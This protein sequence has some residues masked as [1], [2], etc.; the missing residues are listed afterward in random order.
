[1]RPG[2][3]SVRQLLAAILTAAA[4]AT[5][6][7]SSGAPGLLAPK[8]W[9]GHYQ[10]MT[11]ASQKAGTSPATRQPETDFGALFTLATTCSF[12]RC[13]ATVVDGPPPGN[14]TVPT[15]AR[16]TW[17]GT[18]WATSYDWLWDCTVGGGPAGTQ[19]HWAKATSFALYAPQTDG[20][21]R[22]TWHTD[23]SEGPCR[24]TVLMPVAAFPA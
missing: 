17:N 21:L 20:S 22:G 2:R 18:G 12:D 8:P 5:A 13:V 4:L 16:Y 3:R 24:G 6:A 19:K 7:H 10:L 14:P 23:I 1:M 15:P 11:Y 9:E